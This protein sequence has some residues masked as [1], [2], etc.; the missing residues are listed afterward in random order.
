MSFQQTLP[1][2][3]GKLITIIFDEVNY[4]GKP[5]PYRVVVAEILRKMDFWDDVEGC[6]F[7]YDVTADEACFNRQMRWRRKTGLLTHCKSCPKTKR[8]IDP[9]LF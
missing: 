5:T 8:E 9:G 3:E 7:N 2:S 1:T 4:V 6:F